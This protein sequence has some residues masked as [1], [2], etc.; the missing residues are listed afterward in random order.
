MAKQSNRHNR[1]LNRFLAG[2][3]GPFL[4]MIFCYS[5][6]RVRLDGPTLILCNHVTN[7]DPL[8]LTLVYPKDHTHFVCSEHLFRLGFVSKIIRYV[9][10]PIPRRKGTSGADTAMA[11]L[12]KL[13]AGRSVSL[14]VEGECSWDGV[15]APLA[16]STGRLVKMSGV[17]LM[18]CRFEGGYLTAPRWGRGIRR[19]KMTCRVVGKYSP[20]ELKTMDP[21]AIEAL[22]TRDIHTDAW[23][24]QVRKPVAYRSRRRA[25]N[26]QTVLYLCPRCGRSGTLSG[27]GTKLL[28][29]CGKSWEF[30]EFGSFSPAE[31][32]ENI[33][34]WDAWQKE[35]L[36]AVLASGG[37]L[38]DENTTL[39]RLNPDHSHEALHTARLTLKEGVLTCGEYGWNLADIDDLAL[40]MS[41]NLLMSVGTDYYQLKG[42]KGCSMRKY[43]AAWEAARIDTK[44]EV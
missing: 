1:I 21:A 36:P 5:H 38:K 3:A 20:Q 33:T 44:C 7:Y 17:T 16:S 8:L 22:I 23:Q 28:C 19:G 15:T 24:E 6:D 42:P 27:K 32:F 26:L 40:V 2:I 43:R 31:P 12:R 37:V 25:E 14:F 9:V 39:F 34:Q 11:V 10:D 41:R 35:K 13:K 29:S 4:R 30:T 18:T